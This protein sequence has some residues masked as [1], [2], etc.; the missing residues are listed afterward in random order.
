MQQEV[1]ELLK[2][3]WHSWLETPLPALGGQAPMDEVQDADGREMVTALLDDLERREQRHTGGIQQQAYIT[4]AREQLG[5]V[6][7][8][9]SSQSR[10]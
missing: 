5:L 2:A 3:H 9:T 8:P 6:S 4:W 10:P 7:G 1:A